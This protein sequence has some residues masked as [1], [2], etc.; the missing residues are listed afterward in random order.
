MTCNC[1]GK[2]KLILEKIEKLCKE[3]REA[4]NKTSGNN[5]YSAGRCIT[6]E[7]VLMLINEMKEDI[8]D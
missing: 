8:N 6:A 4:F 3:T 7:Q 5:P 2:N 1:S